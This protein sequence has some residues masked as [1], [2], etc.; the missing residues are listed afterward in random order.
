[1]TTRRLHVSERKCAG[2]I[3]GLHMRTAYAGCRTA[4]NAISHLQLCCPVCQWSPHHFSFDFPRRDVSLCWLRRISIITC[5]IVAVT[6]AIRSAINYLGLAA[7]TTTRTSGLPNLEHSPTTTTQRYH[8]Q[9]PPVAEG[10]CYQQACY[11]SSTLSTSTCICTS[12]AAHQ[13]LRRD[14]GPALPRGAACV[15]ASLQGSLSRP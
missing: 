4:S 10:E 5:A 1:V 14:G 7:R 2:C 8:V 6:L 9:N 13:S 15:Q 3:Y 12:H 11:T